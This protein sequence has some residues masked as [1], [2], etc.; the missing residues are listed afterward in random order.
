MN[1][2]EMNVQSTENENQEVEN[3]EDTYEIYM[4]SCC[5]Q[6]IED[7]GYVLDRDDH[8]VCSECAE[9]EYTQCECCGKYVPSSDVSSV[10]CFERCATTWVCDDCLESS[11]GYIRCDN[12]GEWVTE[13][14]AHID[15]YDNHICNRC[16]ECE[17]YTCTGCGEIIHMNHTYWH[18]ACTY[19]RD[20]APPDED[21]LIHEYGH[22]PDPIF[23]GD[24][25]SAMYMG[26]EL[27][28]DK[29]RN[30]HFCAE[31]LCELSEG[32]ELF[33]LKSDGSLYDGIEI[34][35]HPC[36]L[37][38]HTQDFPWT[39]ICQTAGT[40]G[41]L[42]HDADTCGLHVH[43]SRDALGVFPYIQEATIAKIILLV[44]RFWDEIVRFSRRDIEKIDRWAAKP[45]A[46]ITRDDTIST[47]VDKVK[48]A[49]SSRYRAVNLENEHTIEF[50]M[51]RG[52]LNVNTIHATLQF[53]DHLCHFAMDT[54]IENCMDVSWVSFLGC[55]EYP[56]LKSYLDQ[57]GLP[58]VHDGN[59][60]GG[61]S[62]DQ[63]VT[64]EDK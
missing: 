13:D 40:Y 32:E 17:Y 49:S 26:V 54:C 53:V 4:C 37:K 43:V 23:H 11:G 50:R 64:E 5:G 47:A 9:N 6:A 28:I 25:D 60:V 61:D 27:E 39:N 48:K 58:Y 35:T 21:E 3:V 30:R 52:T 2:H 41:F 8:I 57:R 18:D 33:Y 19:C 55:P 20:C 51:F 45:N 31:A 62:I 44:D 34:V 59:Q 10:N 15:D 12:C 36:T 1:T 63:S 14:R 7:D 56:E 22:K 42:S 24:Q 29:G 16:Y 38:Y 46:S